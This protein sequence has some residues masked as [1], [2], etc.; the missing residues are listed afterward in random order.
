MS[1][2]GCGSIARILDPMSLE[3]QYANATA[4]EHRENVV[5]TRNMG[6]G[7]TRIAKIIRKECQ[8]VNTRSLSPY[9][10]C[11]ARSTSAGGS[12]GTGQCLNISSIVGIFRS[13]GGQHLRTLWSQLTFSQA[14][15]WIDA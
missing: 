14:Q 6:G 15:R 10:L 5:L 9:I 7:S 3:T 11:E 2:P 8:N 1:A 13:A 12:M 4:N